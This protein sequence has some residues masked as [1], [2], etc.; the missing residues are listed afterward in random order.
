M[1]SENV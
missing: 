1:R